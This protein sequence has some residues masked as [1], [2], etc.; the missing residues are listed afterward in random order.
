MTKS[1]V[2]KALNRNDESETARKKALEL[3]N[4]LQT[5]MYARQ[6]QGEKRNQEAFAI[7]RDNAKKHPDEWFVHTGLARIFSSQGKW[8]D[9]AKEMKLAVT[10]APDSQKVYLGGLEKKLEAKED[11][12]Q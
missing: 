4:P 11:I 2:L 3:A 6:L 9:A 5:H 12:N 1:N 8:D 10:A 7:F